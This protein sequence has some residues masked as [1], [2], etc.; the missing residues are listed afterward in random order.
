MSFIC[1][2][3][4]IS[5]CFYTLLCAPGEDFAFWL[6]IELFQWATL[7]DQRVGEWCDIY[8]SLPP[9]LSV[10]SDSLRPEGIL[11]ARILEWVA[12]P[13]SR[14][15]SR[16]RDQSQVSH[17]VGRFFTSWA[18]REDCREKYQERQICRWHHPYGRKWRRTKEPL[19]KSERGEWKSWVKVQNLENKDHGIRSYHFMVNRWKNRGNSD[20]FYFGG[21]QNHCGWWLQP[22]N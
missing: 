12:F 19:D 21:L 2:S 18:T 11:Q 20:R 13:F 15:S 9:S 5:P 1:C 6:P 10:T 8:T 7:A 22:W 14:V 3:S 17:I 16:P 4:S